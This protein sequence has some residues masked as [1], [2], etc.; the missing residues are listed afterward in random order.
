MSMVYQQQNENVEV[1]AKDS[2]FIFIKTILNPNQQNTPL[3]ITD[4]I[5]FF[6]NGNKQTVELVV[7]GQ[8]DHFI[9]ADR[10][11]GNLKYKIVAQ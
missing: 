2:I 10:N 1:P 9:I 7:Y 4:T 8:D 5:L 11:I 6:T 3:L